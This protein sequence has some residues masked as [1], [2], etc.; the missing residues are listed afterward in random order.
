MKTGLLL[1]LKASWYE[2]DVVIKSAG[3]IIAV[4]IIQGGAQI[5]F[6]GLV[7]QLHYIS[8][9]LFYRGDCKDLQLLCRLEA[10]FSQNINKPVL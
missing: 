6:L 10:A 4:C 1:G 9:N 7:T 3:T 5:S 2:E 8:L